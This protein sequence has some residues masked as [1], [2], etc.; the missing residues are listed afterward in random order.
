MTGA[1]RI[2]GGELPSTDGVRAPRTRLLR[3]GRPVA[4]AMLRGWYAMEIHGAE[5]VPATG[6]LVMAANHV[7]WLDGPLLAICS[8]RPVHALT[9]QE[10]FVGPLGPFLAASGQIK[11]D[12]FKVDVAAIRSAIKALRT[13]PCGGGVPRGDARRR[14]HDVPTCRCRLPRP[15]DRSPGGAGV[16]PRHPYAGRLGQLRSPREAAGSR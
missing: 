14:R 15:G 5:R 16:V 12:R 1:L 6:P 9:K 10:M 11:L 4:Q 13:G 2:D 3:A 7:G 8:P